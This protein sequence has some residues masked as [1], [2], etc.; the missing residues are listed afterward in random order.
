[1]KTWLSVLLMLA[2]LFMIASERATDAQAESWSSK[3]QRLAQSSPLPGTGGPPSDANGSPGYYWWRGDCYYRYPNS[4]WLRVPSSY[5][6]TPATL[7]CLRPV[8]TEER[9]LLHTLDGSQNRTQEVIQAI[10]DSRKKY[11]VFVQEQLTQDREI[12]LE[13]KCKQ[14]SGILRG[15]NGA[16]VAWAFTKIRESGTL[17]PAST[18]AVDL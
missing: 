12:S 17:R 9:R 1:M 10:M 11:C 2:A 14:Y 4:S 6:A 15:E 8:F 13:D 16:L 3:S 5:C 18:V 7:T